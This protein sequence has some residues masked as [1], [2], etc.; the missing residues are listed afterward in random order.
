MGLQMGLLPIQ[1]L[2]ASRVRALK[3]REKEG[4]MEVTVFW[5]SKDPGHPITFAIFCLVE[6][7]H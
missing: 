2:A 5:L 1:L 4:S 7:T 3:A 6:A